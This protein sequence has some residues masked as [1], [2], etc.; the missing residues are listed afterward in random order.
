[1]MW[2][3]YPNPGDGEVNVLGDDFDFHEPV[4]VRIVDVTG[5][6]VLETTKTRGIDTPLW[7]FDASSWADGMYIIR[8][9]QGTTLKQGMWMKGR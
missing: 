3:P 1:V 8:A 4:V 6:V 7:T 5:K 2:Q 9:T